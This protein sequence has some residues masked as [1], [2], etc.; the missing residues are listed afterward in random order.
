MFVMLVFSKNSVDMPGTVISKFTWPV[1]L[2]LRLNQPLALKL[3]T[4][5]LLKVK[6][7]NVALTALPPAFVRFTEKYATV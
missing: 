6:I 7:S 1:V 3:C 2:T 4:L 5:S